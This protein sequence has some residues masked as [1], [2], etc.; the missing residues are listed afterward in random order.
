VANG[1]NASGSANGPGNN[2]PLIGTG[3]VYYVQAG[4]LM[5]KDLLG[6]SGTLQPYAQLIISDYEKSC[7][8]LHRL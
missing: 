3:K 1:I 4:Y 2:F 6:D 8:A 5:R 7:S